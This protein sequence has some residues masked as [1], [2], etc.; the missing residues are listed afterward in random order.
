MTTSTKRQDYMGRWL[1]NDNPGTTAVTD[2]NGQ[3]IASGTTDYMGRSLITD[4]PTA[5]ATDTAYAVGDLVKR[6]TANGKTGAVYVCTATD[7][8][9]KSDASTEPTWPDLGGTVVDD[10]CT[11]TCVYDAGGGNT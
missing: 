11:W 6:K 9:R 3:T 10:K 5:W 8:D 7:G 4:N 1:N 2:Y